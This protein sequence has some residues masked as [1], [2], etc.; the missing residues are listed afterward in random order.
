M[1]CKNEQSSTLTALNLMVDRREKRNSTQ[2]SSVHAVEHG[3]V[4]SDCHTSTDLEGT[5]PSSQDGHTQQGL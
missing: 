3:R 2:K 1:P 4:L 5:Q